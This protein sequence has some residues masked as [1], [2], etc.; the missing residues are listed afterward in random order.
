MFYKLLHFGLRVSKRGKNK[1]IRKFIMFL[2]RTFFSCNICLLAKIDKTVRFS[3]YGL[4][5]VIHEKAI[6]GAHTQ[7]EVNVVIGENKKDQVP[8]IGNHC[9][10][11][12]GAVLIGGIT[13]GDHVTVGANSVVTKSIPSYTVVAGVPARI[14][15]YKKASNE[16]ID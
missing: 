15:K 6:I 3:H 1:I 9:H 4:G 7:I 16:N 8:V 2:M 5:V 11:G 13:I 14:I 10:I 12:A